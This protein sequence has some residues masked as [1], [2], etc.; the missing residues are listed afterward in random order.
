MLATQPGFFVE[1]WHNGAWRT[2]AALDSKEE[3][4]EC[5]I[6]NMNRWPEWPLREVRVDAYYRPDG[7]PTDGE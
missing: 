5:F 7:E 4:A 3:M 1:R 2:I 6:Q